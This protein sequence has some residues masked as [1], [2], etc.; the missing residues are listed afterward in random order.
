LAGAAFAIGVMGLLAMGALASAEQTIV[1]QWI[2]ESV[3]TIGQGG[4]MFG[5]ILLYR[6]FK[7]KG[8]HQ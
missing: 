1:M 8:C 6:D 5:S 4:F 2:E 7:E 3:N